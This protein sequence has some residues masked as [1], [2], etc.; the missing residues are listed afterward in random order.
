M[1]CW[2]V[3]GI[4]S[5]LCV[6]ALNNNFLFSVAF[7]ILPINTMTKRLTVTAA[8]PPINLACSINLDNRIPQ[9]WQTYDPTRWL[10][11]FT[12]PC[13]TF[14][15]PC[16]NLPR[17]NVG[18]KW[19]KGEADWMKISFPTL[20]QIIQL[21]NQG[22]SQTQNTWMNKWTNESINLA[23]SQYLNVNQ[24]S[25]KTIQSN[26]F[27]FDNFQIQLLT[28]LLQNQNQFSL[29]FLRQLLIRLRSVYRMKVCNS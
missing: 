15:W 20:T 3:S 14:K 6:A 25:F 29:S 12:C 4:I 1:R 24:P 26:S 2:K 9:M 5:N 17:D 7:I 27:P 23:A 16:G 13:D 19:K 22:F 28:Y 18:K 10:K 8:S 21:V 11:Y